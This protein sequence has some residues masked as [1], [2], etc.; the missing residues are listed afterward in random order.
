MPKLPE[1]PA[2][3]TK[4]FDLSQKLVTP[5][6]LPASSAVIGTDEYGLPL[7]AKHSRKSLPA[8]PAVSTDPEPGMSLASC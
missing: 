5:R 7:Y 4:S 1:L 8:I 6:P 2:E 3:P